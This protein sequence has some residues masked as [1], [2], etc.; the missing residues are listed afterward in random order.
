MYRSIEHVLW[1][2]EQAQRMPFL[3]LGLICDDGIVLSPNQD[4]IYGAFHE[5]IE[6]LANIAQKL[7]PL[8]TWVDDLQ[9]PKENI[10]VIFF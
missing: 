10:T 7:A 2:T 4:E 3:D 6:N 1:L 5:I 8:E 9:I